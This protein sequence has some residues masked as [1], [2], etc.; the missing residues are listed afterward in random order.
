MRRCRIKHAARCRHN[1]ETANYRFTHPVVCIEYN[2]IGV[3]FYTLADANPNHGIIDFVMGIGATGTKH[4]SIGAINRAI[5]FR[6]VIGDE[7]EIIY[8]DITACATTI[9]IGFG[10]TF[11]RG[12]GNRC[13]AR[14]DPAR[15]GYRFGKIVVT[16]TGVN[17]QTAS[18]HFDIAAKRSID[19][20]I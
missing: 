5:K 4:R 17:R 8:R 2:A 10:S 15:T 7:A 18:G 14:V 6:G 1:I 19:C 16:A 12:I 9:N 3:N 20:A 11:R 13:G